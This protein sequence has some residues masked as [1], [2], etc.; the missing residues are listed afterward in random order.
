[1]NTLDAT[2]PTTA[3]TTT[4]AP[5]ST[6][7]SGVPRALLRLEGAAVLALATAAYGHLEL[8]SWT[9]F[10][11]AFLAPDLSFAGYLFGPRVGA[12]A[13]NA[14]HSWVGPAV[15]GAVAFATHAPLLGALALIWTGHVGFDRM[16]GYG[17]KYGTAF[18]HT[19]LG[20][21]GR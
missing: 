8:G 13:Y 4:D 12:A 16:L 17:L 14:L 18:G 19:H 21:V 9:L 6:S 3:D 20:R 7:V 5:S 10:F 2:L 1:M 15:L 11:A